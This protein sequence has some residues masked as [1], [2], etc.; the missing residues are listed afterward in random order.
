VNW[1]SQHEPAWLHRRGSRAERAA[2]RPAPR[3]PRAVVLVATILGSS[4]AFVDGTVAN[5]ALPTIGRDLHFGLAGRQWVFLAYSLALAALYLPAGAVGLWTAW[6]GIA[7][8]LGP[9]LGGALVQWASWRLI[10]FINLP[11]AV[12]AAIAAGRAASEGR[13]PEDGRPLDLVGALLLAAGFG[14]LT[15]ALVES[16]SGGVAANRWA[17]AGAAV[18][19]AGAAANE[20]HSDAAMLPPALFRRPNFAAANA[21]TLLVYAGL[22]GSM[23]FLV[24]YLQSI[25]GYTPFEASLTMLPISGLML[26]LAGRFGRLADRHGP[27][28]YL[29]LGPTVMAAGMLLW[30][31]VTRRTDWPPL[32]AG[33]VVFGVGLA[34]TVAPI[35]ATALRAA[36]AQLSGIAAGV[37]N[38]VSRVSGLVAVALIGLVIAR[39]GCGSGAPGGAFGGARATGAARATATDGFRAGISLAAFLCLCGTAVALLAVSNRADPSAGHQAACGRGPGRRRLGAGADR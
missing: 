30:T 19:L 11:L 16:G 6:T 39:V 31:L 13:R 32:A 27:R 12:A 18:A 24:L 23:F 9:P 37:N 17:F 22:G 28:A 8:I 33:V 38:T 7:T 4:M 21:E 20:L 25:V 29:A 1:P 35:A 5:V 36:P 14:S 26:L 15:Y 3:D 10:F 34:I 2:R